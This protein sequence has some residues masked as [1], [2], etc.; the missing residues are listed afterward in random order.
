MRYIAVFLLLANLGYLGWNL[1]N[2]REPA[3]GRMFGQ[4][5]QPLLNTG[6]ITL[7]EFQNDSAL[8]AELNAQSEQQCSL[9]AG[10]QSVEEAELFLVEARGAG[11]L[12]ALQLFGQSLPSHFQVYLPPASSRSIA[13]IVLDGLSERLAGENLNIESYLITRGA[14]ENAVALGIYEDEA[15]ARAVSEQIE[16]LGFTP[17]MD[18]IRRTDGEIE[19]W[20]RPVSQQRVNDSEWLDLSTERPNLTRT[21][22]LCETLVQ[23]PQFQ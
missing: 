16:A 18:E 21:E 22:N 15:S 6:I 1:L 17:E 2:P 9:V 4:P 3:A 23:A 7:A 19:V 5:V 8:Q 14:L 20:L 12:G 11:H 13:T 10:F